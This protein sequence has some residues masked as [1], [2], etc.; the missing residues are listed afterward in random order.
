ML[1]IPRR[2]PSGWRSGASLVRAATVS[3]SVGTN[4]MSRFTASSSS[5]SSSTASSAKPSTSPTTEVDRNPVGMVR[6]DLKSAFPDI[7]L[8]YY[9]SQPEAEHSITHRMLYPNWVFVLA[10]CELIREIWD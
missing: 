9:R 3:A 4:R 2:T 5:A 7:P 6:P 8:A 10:A 1:L